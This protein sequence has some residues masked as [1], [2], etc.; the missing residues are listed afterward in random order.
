MAKRGLLRWFLS[1]ATHLKGAKG[2]LSP[3]WDEGVLGEGKCWER[4]VVPW[5]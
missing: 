4:L 2:P 3:L 5:V 1:G